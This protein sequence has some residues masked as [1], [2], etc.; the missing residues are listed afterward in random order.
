[1]PLSRRMSET[2]EKQAESRAGRADT[3]AECRYPDFL[4]IGAQKAGTTWLDRN[5]RRHPA[6]WLPPLKELHY[7][8]S[9]HIGRHR[10]WTE[11]HRRGHGQRLLRRYLQKTDPANYDYRQ[12]ARLADIVDGPLSDNWYG[13]IFALAPGERMC[14]EVCPDYCLLPPEGIEHVVRLSPEVKIILSLR[15][16]IARSW[17]HLRMMMK[18]RG[19][20]DDMAE[21]E[22]LASSADV[23]ERADYPAIIARWRTFIPDDRLL[24]LFMDDIAEKPGDVLK[25][26]CAFLGVPYNARAFKSADASVH[27]GETQEIPPHIEAMWKETFAPIYSSIIALYPD[28]GQRWHTTYY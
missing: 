18:T 17:S 3:R 2:R 14:G 7:F 12:I 23:A 28:I 25:S 10:K 9:V 8:N 13:R 24:I 1:E 27:V 15:D 20:Q 11:R 19:I 22:R 4:C 5:L 21:V 26:T 16:P 6:L